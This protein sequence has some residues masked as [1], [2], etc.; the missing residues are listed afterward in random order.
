MDSGCLLLFVAIIGVYPNDIG[1]WLVHTGDALGQSFFNNL[2]SVMWLEGFSD[3]EGN[4]S[5]EFRG[6]HEV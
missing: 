4:V 5:Q 3:T 2:S 1:T 6:Q